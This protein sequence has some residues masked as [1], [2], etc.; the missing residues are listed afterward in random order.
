MALR[1]GRVASHLVHNNKGYISA[2]DFKRMHFSEAPAQAKGAVGSIARAITALRNAH[3]QWENKHYQAIWGTAEPDEGTSA[4][5]RKGIEEH[6]LL[7]HV[8]E[9]IRASNAAMSEIRKLP[10]GN[11]AELQ[12]LLQ[13]A[14]EA[15]ETAEK[16]RANLNF[17]Q[18]GVNELKQ[19]AHPTALSR[20]EFVSFL[21]EIAGREHVHRDGYP[22]TVKLAIRSLPE[23]LRMDPALVRQALDN[24]IDDA[25]NHGDPRHP[26]IVT[27][28]SRIV[29]RRPYVHVTVS[30]HGNPIDERMLKVISREPYSRRGGTHGYGKMFVRAVA[31][32]SGGTLHVGNTYLRTSGGGRARS[33][34]LQMQFFAGG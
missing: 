7:D 11:A 34:S 3:Q 9:V 30:N 26:M 24:L 8:N 6:G 2:L 27:V 4:R 21:R 20:Q 29:D 19:M 1:E 10:D 12:N 28:T 31:G 16:I 32:M 22:L 13:H 17:L 5:L 15:R 14:T 33:P 18:S 23:R 25:Q